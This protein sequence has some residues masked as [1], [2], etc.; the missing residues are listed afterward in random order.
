M[1][2]LIQD[3]RYGLRTLGKSPGFAAIALITLALGIGANTAIFSV[4]D[5]ALFHSLPYRAPNRLVHLWETQPSREFAEREASYPN[6][7]EWQASNYVFSELAGYTGA[8]FALTG[9]GAPQRLYA[10][11]TSS[12]FFDALGV[13]PILGRAF[14]PGED[15]AGGER[16]VLLTYA[17]WQGRFGGDPKII[18]QTL[19]LNDESYTVVGIL[20]REFQFAKRGRA[21]IWVPLNPST[22]EATR[23]TFHWVNV[24]G[25]LRPGVTLDQAQSE[26]TR[27]AQR[28]AAEYPDANRGGGIRVV[29]LREEIVG[30]VQPALFALLAAV[31]LVLLIACI[32]VANL[33][34]ARANSRQR[35]IAVRLAL[36][37]SPGRVIRQVLTECSILALLGGGLGILWAHWG[38]R[39]IIARIPGQALARM[40]YF[41]ELSLDGNVLAF[42]LLVSLFTGIAFGLAPALQTTRL[43]LE[44]ALKEGMRSAGATGHQRLRGALVVSEI[45][46][47][48]VLLTGA[49]LLM[50]SLVRLL[51]VS[52]GFETQN[53]LTLE[54][55]A[56]PSR[57]SDP[58][59]NE[60][61]IRQL[62]EGVE[63]LPGVR[64]AATID[65]T[66]FTGGGTFHFTVEGQP[67]P[68]PGQETEANFRSASPNYFHVMGI[69][70]L[71]GRFFGPQDTAAASATVIINKIL[72]DAVFPGQ[73]PIGH[74]LVF[75]FVNPPLVAEIVGLVGDEKLGSLDE[76][77]TP[78]LYGSS[79]QSNDTNVTLLVR[80][81]I[82]PASLTSAV[83]NRIAD[84]D[85]EI[86]VG[87][88]ITVQKIIDD[89]Q[90]A[91]VRRFP[92][93]MTGVFATLAV[94]LSAI[95]IYGVLSYLVSQRTREIGVRMAL[96]AQ[97]GN[98]L[99]MLLN[100]GLRLVA[101]GVAL[102]VLVSLGSA[103]LLTGLLFGVR[104][105]DPSVFLGVAA[106]IAVIALTACLVPARRAT[107]VDPMV[108]LR[109][110]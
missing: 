108:A 42:T 95:G 25:R 21:E 2:T 93:I 97:R 88:A 43:N 53:L 68:L 61:Y 19:T 36:G 104:P 69:P 13:Q 54:V 81:S 23:R 5:A 20:P 22:A 89:S 86:M 82:D 80:G 91:F 14:Q 55:S 77:T 74:R 18:G 64:G 4:V 40:P 52:P 11:R 45:A 35:E 73:D 87:S 9:R 90:S 26:M 98:I 46:L 38:V 78:V 49:G 44:D 102:G 75:H 10:V 34:L 71:R 12:N 57:Y 30:P 65:K 33:L 41:R 107:K 79:F 83:R 28:L 92:A 56:P 109:Y 96:G 8:E 16:V 3:V 85:P 50:K 110:E 27:L 84:F 76:R 59:R 29:P 58:A 106:L 7:I 60:T 32:N 6:L 72:A 101:L 105:N 39:L 31:G 48:L 94:L 15:R 67:P 51:A 100:E 62:V 17:L 70:L 66:P 99:R 24:V 1:D 47:S 37:A 103:R 63:T